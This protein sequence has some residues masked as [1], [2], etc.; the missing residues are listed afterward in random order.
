MSDTSNPVDWKPCTCGQYEVPPGG[1]YEH[2]GVHHTLEGDCYDFHWVPGPQVEGVP[3]W[4]AIPD[5]QPLG[6]WTYFLFGVIIVIVVLCLSL[7]AFFMIGKG[8]P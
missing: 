5:K 1:F 2:E 8:D 7:A 6:E 4:K 3:T